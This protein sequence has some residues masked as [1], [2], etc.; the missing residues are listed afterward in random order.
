MS[1]TTGVKKMRRY[2]LWR[3]FA[4]WFTSLLCISCTVTMDSSYYGG[5]RYYP[6]RTVPTPY[7]QQLS[8][9][10]ES[11]MKQ[12]EQLE[13]GGNV[14]QAANLYYRIAT[15]F[16]GSQ[17]APESLYRLGRI[18]SQQG[19]WHD[20]TLYYLYLVNTYPQWN[21]VGQAYDEL[22]RAF[23]M[24]KRLKEAM[25]VGKR[26]PEEGKRN[27]IFGIAVCLDGNIK[28]SLRYLNAAILSP[29]MRQHERAF[30]DMLFLSKVL[31]EG[32]L[33]A[34]IS[35][36]E[37]S[38]DLRVFARASLGKQLIEVG[39]VAKGQELLRAA[40][41]SIEPSHYL[42]ES[43][44]RL[45][46]GKV[47]TPSQQRAPS[48]EPIKIAAGE[49]GNPRK[50]GLMVP[51]SGSAAGYGYQV[52][53]GATLAVSL[54]NEQHPE[55]P[56]ELVVQ[57]TPPEARPTIKAF[58]KLVNEDKVIAVIGPMSRQGVET[59][60]KSEQ[61]IP[62]PV[63]S[64]VPG[65]STNVSQ[66][67]GS[68]VIRFLPDIR[69]VIERI[70]DY[71]VN[72]LGYKRFAIF[73]PDESFGQQVN[74]AFLQAVQLRGGQVVSRVAYAPG[75]TNFKGAI[76][77]LVGKKEGRAL[78]DKLPFQALFLPDDLKTVSLIVPQLVQANVVGVTLLGSHL[79][80]DPKFSSLSGGYLDGAY[81]VT[82]YFIQATDEVSS[83]FKS[84]FQAMYKTVPQ[85]L[86]AAGYDAANILLQI[87][88]RAEKSRMGL[89][90]LL[91]QGFVPSVSITG[92]KNIDPYGVVNRSY[93]VVTVRGSEPV[94]VAE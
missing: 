68:F 60:E 42:A 50:I 40:M 78:T 67:Y 63:I 38:Q 6:Q 32:R 15:S 49:P 73:Y 86:E 30:E 16:P 89:L 37:T 9:E 81:Y 29:G 65:D 83:I 52:M 35:D 90:R 53:R 7:G 34:I 61:P 69:S 51:L 19:R 33:S 4:L 62:L 39:Q 36:K 92:V 28:K 1:K 57:D 71:S 91:Q 93:K 84:K 80:D 24:E 10:A 13:R 64:M 58:E 94:R 26:I 77:N 25:D 20:A 75:T 27:F 11:L 82:P 44:K 14:S 54:W 8:Q 21:M 87:R 56:V 59:M 66:S 45:S 43:I 2:L 79:W 48:I 74:E 5:E 70:V 31:D 47:A 23:L 46:E 88:H 76:E 18:M 72:T 41:E 12:A 55:D 85:L 22:A 3:C 17:M